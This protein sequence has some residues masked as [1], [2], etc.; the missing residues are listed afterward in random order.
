MGIFKES[1]PEDV[2]YYKSLMAKHNKYYDMYMDKDESVDIF[3]Y[4]SPNAFLQILENNSLRF[5][6]REYLN[7]YGESTYVVNLSVEVAKELELDNK[8]K[9]FFIGKCLK[10]LKEEESFRVYQC[11][12]SVNPDSLCLWNYYTKGDTIKGY[13]LGFDSL[14]L[15]E[16][17][18]PT[19]KPED[20]G[21]FPA[22][23]HGRVNYDTQEQKRII[24][25]IILEFNELYVNQ[26]DIKMRFRTSEVLFALLSV[27]GFFFKNECFKIEEEYKIIMVL[28]DDGEDLY[29]I[30]QSSNSWKKTV[31]LFRMWI[32]RLSR[33]YS[34]G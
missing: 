13:N 4:T 28:F 30:E 24:K 20:D 5:T 12:F 22:I 31:I 1:P 33:R 21:A 7:D 16:A 3:H 11:S 34:E 15:V 23:Y 10:E 9:D 8:F 14:E 27:I 19:L 32:S 18:S 17:L 6:D 29:G 26:G 25:D 2:A